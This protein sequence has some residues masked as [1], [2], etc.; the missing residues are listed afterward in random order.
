MLKNVVDYLNYKEAARSNKVRENE[1]ERHNRVG[2]S[3]TMRHNLAGESLEGGK[4]RESVRHNQTT[5]GIERARVD[6]LSRHNAVEESQGWENLYQMNDLR[7]AQTKAARE[8]AL[9]HKASANLS[10]QKATT[11]FKLRP[12]MVSKAESES[13]ISNKDK[14]NYYWNNIGAGITHSVISAVPGIAKLFVGAK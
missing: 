11:E 6:E 4:L 14:Q 5:E 10:S 7:A 13:A 1:T 8:Q 2:E 12:Y 3:E 9:A